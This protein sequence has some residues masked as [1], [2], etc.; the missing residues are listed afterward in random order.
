[1]APPASKG[2]CA[3]LADL[4]QYRTPPGAFYRHMPKTLSHLELERIRAKF[5]EALDRDLTPDECRYLGL[6]NI[7]LPPEKREDKAATDRSED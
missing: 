2:S 7:A 4:G 5:R 6:A 3:A 1:M